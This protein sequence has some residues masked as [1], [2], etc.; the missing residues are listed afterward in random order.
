MAGLA[1]A[2]GSGAM[3]NSIE[4][5]EF[6]DVIL[7]TGT[8][9]TEN[10]PMIGARVKRAIRQHEAKL[11]VIDPREI[12]LVKYADIWLRQKPG[13]DVAVLNGLM[14]VIIKENL[15]ARDYVAH[16]TEG[17]EALKNVLEKYTPDYV[18]EIS[19]VPADDLK[20]A[21][22]MYAEAD[23]ASILYAMGITQ[24]ITGTDNVKSIANL[25]MLC[26][27]VGIESGGVN[28]LR[29]QNNVQGA[30]DMGALPNVLPAYQQVA[31]ADAR[32]KFE[33]AW[34]VSLS[35]T[36]GLTVTEVPDAVLEGK[37][38]ALYIMGE[39]P[40]MSD[41][42]TTHLKKALEKLDLLVCQ[43]IF[44]NE[45]GELA[46][47]ILPSACFAEKDGTFTN[48]ERRVQMIRKAVEAPGAARPD[49]L[50]IS[51]LATK[52]GYPM[53]YDSADAVMK[54]I[55]E[56]TP[57]YAGIT[58]ERIQAEGI[59]W[60]CPNT[61][62][63]GTRYLHKDQ[64]TRGRGLFHAIEYIPPAELP[65]EEYPFILSTGRV[66]YHYH[67]GTMSRRT[68][69]LVERFP[70]SLIEINPEDAQKLGI[71]EGV[72]VTV[73]SRRGTVTAKAEVTDRPPQ[74]TIFMNFHFNEVAVNT[75]TNPALDPIG[76]I[77][78]YK[79]CAVKVEAA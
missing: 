23:K 69:G 37:I 38:K 79:V 77:P 54:E 62:H 41:P 39:N 43:D 18:E 68:K 63:P 66:L 14:N 73:T 75:L 57:S 36:P 55:N 76:K 3:T 49:W 72:S 15:Y 60:P 34:N 8:N 6:A 40:M 10:H 59:S 22:R 47:V 1:A 48:T 4:E 70:E 74:G 30:C 28:P 29:G 53:N 17:F 44:L 25:A 32:G 78:E 58:Y 52:M 45:T 31:N 65:D 7:A 2:F 50:I 64:F 42:H 71:E 46:D 9:T 5:I 56:L 24:H 12:G 27:N 35:G 19:G 67:T 26:G 16:R 11:I 21:A 33:K 61:D 51:E 13:T 20:K